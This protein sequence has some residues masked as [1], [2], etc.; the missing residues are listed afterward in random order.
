MNQETQRLSQL[1][2]QETNLATSLLDLMLTE[3][4]HLEDGSVEKLDTLAE[5][6]AGYIEQ[7]ET[8]SRKR[9]QLLLALST[10]PTTVARMSLYISQQTQPDRASLTTAVDK[11]EQSLEKCRHQNSVNGMV[12]SMSQRNV[13]R[14]L[15]ILKGADT[16]SMTYTQKGQTT[17]VGKRFSGLKV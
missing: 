12:I 14:N 15:N 11:L 3:K 6:K 13:Q 8:I 5:Q 10:A 2:N 9:T 4:K 16:E 1:I 7:L 17:H